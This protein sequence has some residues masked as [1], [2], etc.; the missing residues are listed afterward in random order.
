MNSN[1]RRNGECSQN[2][3]NTG[4]GVFLEGNCVTSGNAMWWAYQDLRKAGCHVCGKIDMG[5]GCNLK[6]DYVTNCHN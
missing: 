6:V 2:G 4:C 5:N 1:G 3:F